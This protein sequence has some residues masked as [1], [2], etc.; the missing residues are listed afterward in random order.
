MYTKVEKPNES[1]SKAVAN[2]VSQK[3]TGNESTFQFVDNRP[4]GIAQKKLQEMTNINPRQV[5]A[6]AGTVVS[7]KGVTD[8]VLDTRSTVVQ[9]VERSGS[10]AMQRKPWIGTSTEDGLLWHDEADPEKRQFASVSEMLEANK[11]YN[12]D[13]EQEE[14]KAAYEAYKKKA[15]ALQVTFLND[16]N[17]VNSILPPVRTLWMQAE[18]VK[19]DAGRNEQKRDKFEQL[20]DELKFTLDTVEYRQEALASK[21][22]KEEQKYYMPHSEEA[23]AI[24]Y[25]NRMKRSL[26]LLQS[27]FSDLFLGLSELVPESLTSSRRDPNQIAVE[28]EFGVITWRAYNSIPSPFN[29]R[30]QEY[31]STMARAQGQPGLHTYTDGQTVVL[32]FLGILGNQGIVAKGKNKDGKHIFKNKL[33][34]RH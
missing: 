20:R 13:E 4:D 11:Q 23:E 21:I 2:E 19:S 17:E 28:G 32:K 25:V 16:L 27:K 24:K 34:R 8:N 22:E 12:I 30:V 5:E 29:D 14:A 18:R 9:M 33:S 15:R 3:Q 31:L 7:T 6:S 1:K 26:K 10:A